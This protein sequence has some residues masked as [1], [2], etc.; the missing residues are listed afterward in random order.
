[1]RARGMGANVIVT[2]IDL[3]RKMAIRS[4]ATISRLSSLMNVL[5][6]DI[7]CGRMLS[8]RERASRYH[9]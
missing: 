7:Y 1:M 5:F 2:E 9:W 4:G 8:P 3:Q 6:W